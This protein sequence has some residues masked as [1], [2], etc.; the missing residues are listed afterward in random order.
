MIRPL[1][2]DVPPVIVL[3]AKLDTVTSALSNAASNFKE[4]T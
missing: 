2:P 4:L 1:A 3:P